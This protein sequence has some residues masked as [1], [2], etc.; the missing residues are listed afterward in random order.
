[1]SHPWT[2]LLST[3]LRVPERWPW[4]SEQGQTPRACLPPSVRVFSEA[5]T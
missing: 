3:Q 2:L 4:P 5:T 1:M